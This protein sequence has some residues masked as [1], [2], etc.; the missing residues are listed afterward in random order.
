MGVTLVICNSPVILPKR[1]SC[2]HGKHWVKW[3]GW[4]KCLSGDSELGIKITEEVMSFANEKVKVWG[5]WGWMVTL[6]PQNP[7]KKWWLLE[8]GCWESL[9]WP[10][11][12]GLDPRW[13][14]LEMLWV[15]RLW[16]CW[17][18]LG[19]VGYVFV[20][21]CRMRVYCSLFYLVWGNVPPCFSS[22]QKSREWGC[23]NRLESS[24][25]EPK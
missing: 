25:H 4:L 20:W 11:V 8:L 5:G 1:N 13:C 7:G 17:K 10:C 14:C 19:H 9:K 3:H 2:L 6:K 24:N 23:S 21:D 15:F 16:T 18:S 12:Q 22:F